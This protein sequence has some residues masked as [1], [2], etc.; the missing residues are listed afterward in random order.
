MFRD[1]VKE[2]ANDVSG[3]RCVGERK[4]KGSEWCSEEIGVVVL[5]REELLR[6]GFREDI[7]LHLID[8]GH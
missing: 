5:E 3:V 8:T 6:N 2:C 7:V 1:R 4:R